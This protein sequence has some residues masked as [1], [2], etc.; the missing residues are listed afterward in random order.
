MLLLTGLH[1]YLKHY[2]N[3]TIIL[4]LLLHFISQFLLDIDFKWK[5]IVNKHI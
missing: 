4:I 5:P 2:Y 3:K 1:N